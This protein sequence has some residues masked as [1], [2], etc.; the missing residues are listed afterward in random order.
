MRAFAVASIVFAITVAA[1]LMIGV[2]AA[3]AGTGSATWSSTSAPTG[4][5]NNNPWD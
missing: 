3:D 2:D 4:P 1:A 5:S